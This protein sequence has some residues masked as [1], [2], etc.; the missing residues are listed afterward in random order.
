MK[1][2]DV[3]IIGGGIVGLSS[4]YYLGKEGKSVLVLDKGD[5]SDGCSFGNAGYVSPSHFVTLSSPGI[6]SKGL[7]WMMRSDSPFYLKP[8]LNFDLARWGWQFM[9]HSTEK[10]VNNSKKLLA[11]LSL[12]SRELHKQIAGEASLKFEENGVML[13][14]K[15]EETLHHEQ[16]IGE[17]ASE[18]GIEAK[19]MTMEDI[20][21][22]D[23]NVKKQGAGGVFFPQDAY[24][25]PAIFMTKL[26]EMVS[27]LDVTIKYN[28]EVNNFEKK[29]G[30]IQRV[31]VG[32]EAFS[33]DQYVLAAGSFSPPL[34]KK[35]GL[36]LLLEAGKGYS[37][38]WKDPAGMPTIS[39]IF[40][41]ARVAITPL[42]NK[43]RL[44]GTMEIGGLDESINLTRAN[45]FLN[46]IQD[47]FPEYEFNKISHLPKWAGLRPCS[48]DGLPY[49]GRT[50]K[51]KNLILAA[52]HAMMGFTLGPATGLL[53]KEIALEENTSL[54]IS[55]LSANRY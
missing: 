2:Y 49:I 52:G 18:L 34:M 30:N 48:P 19:S 43:V 33:A 51:Y 20:D 24:T 36:R 25:D 4:A 27:Q 3:I 38:D 46:S 12:L 17:M 37:V 29:G 22:L 55:R 53:V 50:N 14:C 44:A 5:G 23:P 21:R 13:L 40:V 7:R 8:R 39:Y 35:L 1:H 11:D 15:T 9:R 6:V 26:S 42:D 28:S 16:K 41:E 54:E 32:T 31:F 10:H 45:G 47:Y